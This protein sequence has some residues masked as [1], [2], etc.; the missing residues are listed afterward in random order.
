MTSS[1]F[2][3]N[4]NLTED[5]IP[6]VSTAIQ[7]GLL[8]GLIFIIYTLTTNILEFSIPTSILQTFLLFVIN[9]S[10]AV[11]ALFFS[12]QHHRE[13]EL[14]GIIS[15]RRA[16]LVGL[17]VL[18][19][20][21]MLNTLFS[22]VYSLYIEPGFNSSILEATEDM[23]RDMGLEEDMIEQALE[24]ASA[25]MKPANMLKQT[26]LAGLLSSAVMAAIMRREED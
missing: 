17:V 12:I 18:T 11:T 19:T 13:Q 16:F 20:A 14:G 15:F 25:S 9:L 21:V 4:D 10:L 1:P 8:A 2:H 23:M 22:L 7:Q 6:F 3:S 26:L 24:D 5:D